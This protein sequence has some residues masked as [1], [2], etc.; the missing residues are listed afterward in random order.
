M[1]GKGYGSGSASS[2]PRQPEGDARDAGEA[3][4]QPEGA[5]E[6]GADAIVDELPEEAELGE[7]NFAD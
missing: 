7:E 3:E 1:E 4:G 6:D 5:P 2:V